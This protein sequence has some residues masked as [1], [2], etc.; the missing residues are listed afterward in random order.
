MIA[1]G[2]PIM[3]DPMNRRRLAVRLLLAFTIAALVSATAYLC[4][5]YQ[6]RGFHYYLLE[7]QETRKILDL[8]REDIEVHRK[9]TGNLPAQLADLECVKAE[10][11]P[12]DAAGR[13][14]DMWGRP[15]QYRIE[16]DGYSVF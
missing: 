12:V 4:A 8:L 7:Q 10:R 15:F 1:E 6:Y 16:A 5:W 3:A 11:V 13:P 14:R 2:I 9:L